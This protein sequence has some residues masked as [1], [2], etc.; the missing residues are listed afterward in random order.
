MAD[1]KSDRPILCVYPFFYYYDGVISA[2]DRAMRGG[3]IE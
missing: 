1:D 2:A 3:W